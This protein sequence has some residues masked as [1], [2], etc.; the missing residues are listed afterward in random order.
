[1]TEDTQNPHPRGIVL[2][3]IHRQEDGPAVIAEAEKI[4]AKILEVPGDETA[5]ANAE[6]ARR[7]FLKP[8]EPNV[9]LERHAELSRE[10]A[11]FTQSREIFVERE[12][13]VALAERALEV[14]RNAASIIESRV[15]DVRQQHARD[16]AE[17][18]T[19]VRRELDAQKNDSERLA[20]HYFELGV[21]NGK[22]KERSRW[23]R[24]LTRI[25][26]GEFSGIVQQF[27]KG[28]VYLESAAVMRGRLMELLAPKKKK[29]GKR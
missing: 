10:L 17:L 24:A 29:G 15:E 20:A 9:L 27:L 1:M 13:I 18:R 12:P 11:Q 19:I 21:E 6:E 23:S 26:A 7:R 8:P 22:R 3:E 25:P 5:K 4:V 2:H 14:L 28:K 16:Q